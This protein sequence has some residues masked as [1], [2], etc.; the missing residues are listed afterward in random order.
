MSWEK[1]IDGRLYTALGERVIF[2]GS[3]WVH[4]TY[5]SGEHPWLGPLASNGETERE[6]IIQTLIPQSLVDPSIRVNG[7]SKASMS[8]LVAEEYKHLL[9]PIQPAPMLEL[10]ENKT[11][12]IQR[13]A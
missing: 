7:E 3:V 11:L 5:I 9:Q 12:S 1:A 2:K 13:A 8:H 6:T 10:V 4:E